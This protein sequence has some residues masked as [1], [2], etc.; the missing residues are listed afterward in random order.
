MPRIVDN[1]DGSTSF[2]LDSTEIRDF[3]ERQAPEFKKFVEF[4]EGPRFRQARH[5]IKSVLR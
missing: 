5:F 3:V 1:D 2:I 4:V